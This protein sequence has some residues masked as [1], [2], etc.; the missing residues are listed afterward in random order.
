MTRLEQYEFHRAYLESE[1]LD[2]MV[3]FSNNMNWREGATDVVSGKVKF[4]F[5]P[6]A[7]DL[8]R[9]HKLL[10]ER[11]CFTVMEF[12]VG[13]STIVMADALR[14]NQMDWEKLTDKPEI[15]NRFMFKI[16]S[17]DASKGWME[18]T[19]KKFPSD[20]MD[21]V[22]FHYS[23]V[24]IGTHNGQLCH[25]YKE[26]P[27][28]V[29]DFIYL[30]GPAQ[31][32]VKGS[33]RGLSFQCE[34]RTVM[35]ADLLLMEPTF[36]PGLFI[37]VDGRTN[38]ARFLQRNFT[39]KWEVTW[40]R[41]DDVTTFE[42]AEEPLGRA[43][44]QSLDSSPACAFRT[45]PRSNSDPRPSVEESERLAIQCSQNGRDEKND[46]GARTR[47]E[48]LRVKVDRKRNHPPQSLRH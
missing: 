26:L 48:R 18:Q 41:D 47:R 24:E 43:A 46:T 25:Y 35:S 7:G 17:V 4:A 34:E 37:V 19:K 1:G 11:K 27:D 15:R 44:C 20:L 14:K 33:I 12:G 8:V 6:A 22:H 30:D 23:E 39:R 29:P 42:L 28:I 40:D 21:R 3:D 9:L 45:I 13:H 10:R 31:S 32:D 16:F 5:P 36:L 2:R 38:N